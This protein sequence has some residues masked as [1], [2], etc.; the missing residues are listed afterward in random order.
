MLAGLGLMLYFNGSQAFSPGALSSISRLGLELSGYS[1]HAEFEDQCSLCH[2]PLNTTQD[3]L[4]NDCHKQVAEQILQKNGT[5]GHIDNVNQCALCHSDHQGRNF[6]MLQTAFK[7]FD[8]SLT[9]FSLAWHQ[10][11]YD[12]SPMTCLACHTDHGEFLVEN[13]GCAGCHAA[14]DQDYISLHVRNYGENCTACHDG[15][16]RMVRFD[17]QQTAFAL[18]GR[19]NQAE[20]ADCHALDVQPGGRGGG[21]MSAGLFASTSSACVSCHAEPET[22]RGMFDTDCAA[23]HNPQS[24]SPAVLEGQPFEHMSR[25]GFSLRRHQDDF[26]G[27][28]LVC[29]DC[30]RGSLKDFDQ[31]SCITCH[32]LDRRNPDFMAQHQEDYSQNCLECHDGMDRMENFD[33]SS[34]FILGGR[35]AEINCEDCH[36]NKKFAGTPKE[37]VQCHE[38]PQLHA[39]FFGVQCQSC[40]GDRA[41]APARLRIH[42]FPLNHGSPAK[43]RMQAMPHPALRGIH[44]LWMPRSPA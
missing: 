24:W 35:H 13:S 30:H 6:D 2:Q 20:C 27:Q 9:H 14:E 8:H 4:C 29:A 17:H 38:E 32:T 1:S 34:F 43:F 11:N 19:H 15:H 33:H 23:C 16:D 12:T 39:G 40:H 41:W 44:L 25:T 21:Q 22:H 36:S 5:H 26:D 31:Q 37:C 7:H 42:S 28:S 10:V 3:V 18:T